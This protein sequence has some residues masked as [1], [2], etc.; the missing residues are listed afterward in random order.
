MAAA[1]GVSAAGGGSG[2]VTLRTSAETKADQGLASNRSTTPIHPCVA[3]A[4]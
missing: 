3:P 4:A 2:L 1:E